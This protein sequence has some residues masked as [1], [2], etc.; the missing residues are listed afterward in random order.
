MTSE[1]IAARIPKKSLAIGFAS[2]RRTW[3][4][5][6]HKILMKAHLGCRSVR[7]VRWVVKKIP[8]QIKMMCDKVRGHC[9]DIE[10]LLSFRGAR[11]ENFE[12]L[13]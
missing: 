9:N 10:I 6:S 7:R 13:L 4:T 11:E 2:R 5:W 12:R 3:G 8:V 1:K